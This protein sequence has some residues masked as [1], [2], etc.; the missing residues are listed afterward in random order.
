MLL[1]YRN[2][3]GLNDPDDAIDLVD[4]SNLLTD[5]SKSRGFVFT[6]IVNKALG[7]N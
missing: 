3:A 6:S 4:H 5:S 7:N 1:F 2:V